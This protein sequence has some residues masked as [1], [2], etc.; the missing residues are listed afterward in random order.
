MMFKKVRFYKLLLIEI[1][2]TLCTLCLYLE[3]Q[4][5]RNRF[6][7]SCSLTFVQHFERLKECSEKLRGDPWHSRR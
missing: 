1:I 4:S 3:E 5:R 7:S 6:P 2:E